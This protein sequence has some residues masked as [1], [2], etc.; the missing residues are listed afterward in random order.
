MLQ[1]MRDKFTGTFALVILGMLGVSFIFFGLNYSFIGSGFVA[2]IDGEEIAVS[3]FEQNYRDTIQRNPQWATL[4]GD[5][6]L[7]LRRNVLDQLIG[8]QLIENY[9]NENGYRVSDD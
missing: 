3:R 6:R 8:E 5:Q 7:I 2:K 9:L 4:P 1:T